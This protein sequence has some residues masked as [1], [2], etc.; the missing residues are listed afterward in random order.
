MTLEHTS[1]GTLLWTSHLVD[2][3]TFLL[4]VVHEFIYASTPE[5]TSK[6]AGI[7]IQQAV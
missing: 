3:Q 1:P 4:K 7:F 5:G 6:I 2:A